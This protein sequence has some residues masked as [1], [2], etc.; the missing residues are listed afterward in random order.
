MVDIV[1]S[2]DKPT[3]YISDEEIKLLDFIY[4]H[5]TEKAN[6]VKKL[7]AHYE[8]TKS[9]GEEV[10]R[11]KNMAEDQPELNPMNYDEEDV[12]KLNDSAV[13]V[14]CAL[15]KLVEK[16]CKPLLPPTDKSE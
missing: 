9:I 16:I 14:Y 7:I 6:V 1:M 2:D 8:A 10:I 11:I 13:D 3:G 15:D 5:N 12:R 4:I